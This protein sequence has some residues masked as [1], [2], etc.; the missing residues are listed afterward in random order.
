MSST[1]P[2]L[3]AQY[4]RMSTDRQDLSPEIQMDAIQRYASR[5]GF[6]IAR[7]YLDAGISGRTLDG[8]A[9]MKRLL[10]DVTR[11]DRQFSA[12]L[13]YD[14]SSWGRFQDPDASAYYEYHCRLHGVDVH[15]VQEPFT[16]FDTPLA[17]LFKGMKRAMAAEFSRELSIKTRAGLRAA[18]LAGFQ[19]GSPPALGF[20]KV[21]VSKAD[22]SVRNLDASQRRISN[23]EHVRWVHAP[24]QELDLVRRIF[25]TYAYSAMSVEDVAEKFRKEGVVGRTGRPLTREML[26]TLFHSEALKG[27]YVW[28]RWDYVPHKRRRRRDDERL[29]RIPGFVQPIV[30]AELFDAV[31]SKLRNSH[32]RYTKEDLLVRLRAALQVK[33]K[34]RVS[35]LLDFGCPTKRT[36]EWAFGSVRTAWAAAGAEY[37]EKWTEWDHAEQGALK[38]QSCRLAGLIELFLVQAGVQCEPCSGVHRRGSE[39]RIDGNVVVRVQACFR[40]PRLSGSAWSLRKVYYSTTYDFV[41]VVRSERNGGVVDS[42]LFTRDEYF[43]CGRWLPDGVPDGWQVHH[44]VEEV[45]A[46]LFRRRTASGTQT[47]DSHRGRRYSNGVVQRPRLPP[48]D[49]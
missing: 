46:V 4:L 41:L 26:D 14:V 22:R 2:A 43:D 44:T 21:A 32:R 10:L 6:V 13:V 24:K 20:R 11:A 33:P 7:T 47:A 36:L 19:M 5:H 17:S 39:L 28:N 9:E 40:R 23:L 31:Q 29:L 18:V 1:S 48:A 49:L 3:A 16:G 35:D 25:E 15:Y 37:P 27:E 30:S 38:A 12:V 34:L 42:L 8:R 45:M